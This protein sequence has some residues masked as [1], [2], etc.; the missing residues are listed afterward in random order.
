MQEHGLR[1]QAVLGT[2]IILVVASIAAVVVNRALR[3]LLLTLR[4]RVRVPSTA[5]LSLARLTSMVV[6]VCAGMLMLD[7][8]GLSV[9]GL[10]T[11]LVSTVAVIG[12]GFLAVWTIISNATASFFITLWHPFR[13]GETVEILPEAFAG[14]VV[15]RNLMFTVLREKQGATLQVP[16][17]LF[18]QKIFRVVAH[19]EQYLFESLERGSVPRPGA[20]APTGL[21]TTS[22]AES[23]SAEQK[24]QPG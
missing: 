14:R 4:P 10:W 19:G 17:N 23:A 20:A 5:V 1:G 3:R 13:L 21:T 22:A 15:E 16:N 24:A 2:A 11:F 9:T 12:V 18:F 7:V 6:W 8:W